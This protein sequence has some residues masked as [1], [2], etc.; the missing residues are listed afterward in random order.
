MAANEKSSR[1]P[2]TTYPAS[3]GEGTP[4]SS[5]SVQTKEFEQQSGHD[6]EKAIPLDNGE[7]KTSPVFDEKD[8][9]QVSSSLSPSA[10]PD[11]GFQAWLAVA[12]GFCTGFASFGWINCTNSSMSKHCYPTANSISLGIGI[13][14]NYYQDNQLKS[15]SSSTISW[16]PSTESF[17]LF[18]FVSTPTT[19]A[20]VESS[21]HTRQE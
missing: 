1:Y 9:A 12:G 19:T 16:I 14:Q 2:D 18:F 3:P 4:S 11:G 8:Q 10:P 7:E 15:Y 20:S 13:F 6:I 17:M 21:I 5:A